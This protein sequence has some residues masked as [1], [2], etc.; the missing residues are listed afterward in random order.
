MPVSIGP[1]AAENEESVKAFNLRLKN[2]GVHFQ[3]PENHIP[4]WLPKRDHDQLYSEFFLATDN[5]EVRGAYIL[6]HQEFLINETSR[7]IGNF[8]LPLSEGIVDKQYNSIGLRLL[9]DA[10]TRQPQLYALG[11]GGLN[12]PLPQL[13]TG[14]GWKLKLVPFFFHVANPKDFLKQISIMRQTSLKRLIGDFM[15]YSG[16]GW[17]TIK[18]WQAL[19]TR[20]TI[21]PTQTEE[22]EGFGDWSDEIWQNSRG[23]YSLGAVRTGQF[24]NTLYPEKNERF[25][26][27]KIQANDR[28]VGWVV[29]LDTKMSGHKYFGNLRVGTIVDC[30]AQIDFEISVIAAAK[31][32]L[33][34]RGVDLIVSNQ[35]HLFWL[36]ACEQTGFLKGPSNFALAMSPQLWQA[37]DISDKNWERVHF[38][39]GDG[40]GPIN[41]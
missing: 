28:P 39:R 1:Y 11:M 34:N 26:K 36:N 31:K 16:L 19:I 35:S 4:N 23:R 33:V 37:V 13:L 14:L 30:I 25:I 3:F 2:K 22:F 15:A 8:G 38:T 24:L 41:L 21:A 29:L 5:G 40:D 7:S 9:N 6:K 18:L 17:A 20:K 32:F 10:L 12:K 27:L